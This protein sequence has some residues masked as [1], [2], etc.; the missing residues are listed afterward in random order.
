[1]LP[2]M[3]LMSLA[4][5][6]FPEWDMDTAPAGM[7]SGS[8]SV[9]KAGVVVSFQHSLHDA[10]V[11]IKM[12]DESAWTDNESAYNALVAKAHALANQKESSE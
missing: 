5:K 2:S 6:A 9:E 4:V 3:R 10:L 11:L 1:M 12:G 7:P 8:I